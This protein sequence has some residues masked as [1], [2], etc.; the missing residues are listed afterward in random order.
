MSEKTKTYRL[1][2]KAFHGGTLL[3]PGAVVTVAEDRKPGKS[4][5]PLGEAAKAVPSAPPAKPSPALPAGKHPS[6]DPA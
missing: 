5:E 3:L 1:T 4:W 6:K 2:E